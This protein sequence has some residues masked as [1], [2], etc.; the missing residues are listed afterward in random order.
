MPVGDELDR[1]IA[2][3]KVLPAVSSNGAAPDDRHRQRLPV[4][5]DALG[6]VPIDWAALWAL[7]PP[8]EEWSIPQVL[9]RGREGA[10][11]GSAGVGKSL[12]AAD[13]AAAKAT[14]RSVLGESP[15]A[16]VS[17]VYIDAEMT[18]GDLQERLTDLGY[19]PGDD[20][21]RLHYYQ[22]Q[23]F[24]PLDT[25]EGGDV[26]MAIVEGYEAESVILDTMTALVEGDESSADTYRAF[27][28]N[29]AQRLKAAGVSLLRIDHEGKDPSK[30]QRGSSAKGDE[31]DVVWRLSTNDEQLV[32][33]NR[34]RR[35]P[36]VAPTVA[37][38]RQTEPLLRHVL[39]PSGVPAGTLDTAN[40]LGTLDVALDAT[41]ATAMRAL[42]EAGHGRRKM[43]VLAAMR[44]RGDRA[45]AVPGTNIPESPPKAREPRA[46]PISSNGTKVQVESSASGSRNQREPREP[47]SR[48][49]GSQVPLSIEGTRDQGDPA[50]AEQHAEIAAACA[51]FP[52]SENLELYQ[53]V[54]GRS[55]DDRRPLSHAEAVVLI[56]AHEKRAKR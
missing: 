23:M 49:I 12:V 41:A 47:A 50:T 11:Y 22:L 28:R 17:V 45:R 52:L 30:G 55:I 6:I 20:L 56:A 53:R 32:L 26:L 44:L 27:H 25:L 31:A 51:H 33:T 37:I 48:P 19:G 5:L 10:I 24:P 3:L 14:G 42:K 54:T 15:T 2:E 9:P 21:S 36:Y 13:I 16:P 4:D 8:G 7:D 46:E 29:T 43:V 1:A 35:V 38:T 39:V 34:K 18:A 40:L